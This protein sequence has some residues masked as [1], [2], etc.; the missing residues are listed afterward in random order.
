MAHLE[1]AFASAGKALSSCV[2]AS[3]CHADTLL[4]VHGNSLHVRLARRAM[5][6]RSFLQTCGSRKGMEIEGGSDR[7]GVLARGAGQRC[8]EAHGDD[9]EERHAARRH[10]DSALVQLNQTVALKI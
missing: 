10:I 8:V 9:P 2:R 6:E 3:H 4:T 5:R 1:C 7:V